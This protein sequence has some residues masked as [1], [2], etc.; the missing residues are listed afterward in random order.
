MSAR[1]RPTAHR[2]VRENA[3]AS[4][5]APIASA[6]NSATIFQSLERVASQPH[7]KTANALRTKPALAA[8][9]RRG[10]SD[11]EGAIGLTRRRYLG[12]LPGLTGGDPK[13]AARVRRSDRAR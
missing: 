11:G 10:S 4:A 1:P 7:A 5:A 13:R 12:T 3:D 9:R 2:V 6:E 8:A